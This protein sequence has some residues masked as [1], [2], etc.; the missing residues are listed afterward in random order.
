MQYQEPDDESIQPT[1]QES[2]ISQEK[3]GALVPIRSQSPLESLDVLISR[4]K[5]PEELKKLLEL[6]EIA[7][8][9]QFEQNQIEELKD[10]QSDERLGKRNKK[11]TITIASS[12]T[13]AIGLG[14]M[15]SPSF[16]FVG[17]V[18][19]FLGVA[20]LLN[21]PFD[22]LIEFIEKMSRIFSPKS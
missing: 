14:I 20:T 12:V 19:L 1:E 2:K 21:I 8:K 13:I 16:Q 17:I 22:D 11:R 10:K 5:S 9:Q 18:I 15:Y 4:E 6:K 7:L 3:G